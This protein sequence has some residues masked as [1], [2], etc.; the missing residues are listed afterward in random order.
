MLGYLQL[1][2][3]PVPQH[4]KKAAAI[5]P[6]HRSVFI[7]PPWKEIF[8]QD[9]ERKQDFDEAQRTYDA[10]ASIYNALSYD[11]IEL[12][13]AEVEDRCQFILH[14]LETKN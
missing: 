10:L 7:A 6:Y 11:L 4:M 1:S 12:P 9:R 3:I 8:R 5:F 13:R 14:H 2:S